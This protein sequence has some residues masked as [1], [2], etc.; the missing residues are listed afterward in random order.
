MHINSTLARRLG[1]T[2]KE[3]FGKSVLMLYPL[4]QRAEAGEIVGEMLSGA[5]SFCSIPVIAKSGV[6]IPYPHHRA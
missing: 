5:K 1:Y 2:E 3:L 6:Q 4:E